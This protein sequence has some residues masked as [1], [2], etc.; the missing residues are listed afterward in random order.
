LGEVQQ[1]ISMVIRVLRM[2]R[3]PTKKYKACVAIDVSGSISDDNVKEFLGE[4]KWLF[5]KNEAEI[6]WITFDTKITESRILTKGEDVD[7]IKNVK[8][9]GGTSFKE[10]V[11][12]A[13]DNDMDDLIVFT[14]GYGDQT[15]I[16]EPSRHLN[17]WWVTNGYTEFPWGNVLK[18]GDKR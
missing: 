15:E 12:Y 11:K 3:K 1:A 7:A 10:P 13:L 16:H 17:V 14:D 5:E 6:H 4:I 2:G 18:I 9:R 8:G